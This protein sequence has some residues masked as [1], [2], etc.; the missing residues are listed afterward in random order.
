[1]VRC[2]SV[3]EDPAAFQHHLFLPLLR[4]LLTA[5]SLLPNSVPDLLM[6]GFRGRSIPKVWRLETS[7]L[8]K[9]EFRFSPGCLA[10][11]QKRL[12]ILLGPGGVWIIAGNPATRRHGA[13]GFDKNK[14]TSPGA[15]RV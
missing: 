14:Y 3:D 2:I 5:P 9:M 13:H 7:R 8:E 6:V 15:L 11:S 4:L 12:N 10:A 1:M